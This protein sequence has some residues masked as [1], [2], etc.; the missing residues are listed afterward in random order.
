VRA[1]I[2]MRLFLRSQRVARIAVQSTSFSSV[3]LHKCSLPLGKCWPTRRSR[4]H[5]KQS[6]AML[7]GNTSAA[8]LFRL[9]SKLPYPLVLLCWHQPHQSGANTLDSRSSSS[10]CVRVC[11]AS[12]LSVARWARGLTRLNLCLPNTAADK[13]PARPKVESH[14]LKRTEPA[15][16]ER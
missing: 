1:S 14:L 4:S 10:T 6:G 7:Q 15:L 13:R 2:A 5:S 11:P 9:L 12:I 8:G 3:H 16:R